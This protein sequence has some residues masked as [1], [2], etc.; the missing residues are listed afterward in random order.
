[1]KD[2][3]SLAICVAYPKG[4]K[5]RGG[6]KGAINLRSTFKRKMTERATAEIMAL[7]GRGQKKAPNESR[8]IAGKKAAAT[9]KARRKIPLRGLLKNKRLR[10]TY[11]G[12]DYVAWVLPSGRIKLRHNGKIFDSPSGAA[13][14]I[15]KKPSNGWLFWHYQ[16]KKGSWVPLATLRKS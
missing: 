6:F 11:K 2:L 16:D 10:K 15:R 4:N 13:D 5:K 8:R 3:E 14:D 9:R 12:H 7:M 1:M